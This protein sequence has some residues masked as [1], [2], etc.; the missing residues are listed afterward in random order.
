MRGEGE[1]NRARGGRKEEGRLSEKMATVGSTSTDSE[2]RTYANPLLHLAPPEEEEP[3]SAAAA[4]ATSNKRSPNSK[5]SSRGGFAKK[6]PLL[7]RTK[8]N[9]DVRSTSTIDGS[10]S[11]SSPLLASSPDRITPRPL[12]Q[13]QR[14]ELERHNA[15][16]APQ[17]LAKWTQK[18]SAEERQQKRLRY[19]NKDRVDIPSTSPPTPSAS[20]SSSPRWVVGKTTR[21]NSS[22]DEHHNTRW[23]ARNVGEPYQSDDDEDG[24]VDTT[25]R[26]R[27]GAVVEALALSPRSGHGHGFGGGRPPNARCARAQ[28][29]ALPYA[30]TAFESPER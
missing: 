5:K 30:L 26:E 21:C 13:L 24:D 20:A 6:L 16:V 15:A 19:K 28:L 27:R 14:E 10:S 3:S 9:K 4:A 23:N 1:G 22:D 12:L 17:G 7:R 25:K 29:A 18:L 2:L 8:S 11:S